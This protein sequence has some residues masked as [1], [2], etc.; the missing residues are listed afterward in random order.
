MKKILFLGIIGLM[1]L[2]LSAQEFVDLGL[3][4]GTKWK[5]KNESD[6][7]NY[8]AALVE[9]G[10]SLPTYA[11]FEELKESCTWEWNGKGFKVTGPNGNSIFLPTTSIRD[12]NG[13]LLDSSLGSYAGSY[14]SSSSLGT[15]RAW[16][17]GFGATGGNLGEAERCSWRAVRLIK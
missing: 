6:L 15:E 4:S 8:N 17:L 13:D 14:W 9:F 5:D 12:C 2:S 11:Q 10:G 3:S 16:I 7:F 1:A